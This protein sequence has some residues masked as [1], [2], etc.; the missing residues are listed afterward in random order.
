M[1]VRKQKR[2]LDYIKSYPFPAEI[3]RKLL[4]RYPHL[5]ESQGDRVLQGLRSY[6]HICRKYDRQTAMPSLVVDAAWH[7][8]LLF[9]QDYTEFSRGALG[10]YFQHVPTIRL[11]SPLAA[12]KSLMNAWRRSCLEEDIDPD[13]PRRLPLLFALDAELAIAD[14]FIYSIEG[15]IYPRKIE[16]IP[17][18]S[19]LLEIEQTLPL[20]AS[21]SQ[22]DSAEWEA[23]TKRLAAKIKLF[24]FDDGYCEAHGRDALAPLFDNILAHKDLTV[25]L[26]G[27]IALAKGLLLNVR[28]LPPPP[29]CGC[30]SSNG[31]IDN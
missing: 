13:N 23:E 5:T 25:A 12:Q 17:P 18:K 31:L 1:K 16:G 19:L 4:A 26:F 9:S 14:G 7:E 21:L 28:K 27:D 15:G 10:H 24:L 6:F 30:S 22:Q 20:K 8:F 3:K 2:E 11:E 29:E